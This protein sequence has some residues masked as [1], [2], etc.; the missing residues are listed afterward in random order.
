MLDTEKKTQVS[1]ILRH[2]ADSIDISES[3]YED[4]VEKY[5]AVG[6][7]LGKEGSPL[8]LYNPEISPQGSFNLGTIVK[9]VS[10]EDTYDIDLVCQLDISQNGI[11]QQ[12]LKKMV[13]D[14]LKANKT[15]AG[16]L[17]KEGRRCWT[18]NYADGANFHMDILPA[19]PDDYNWL[20]E[21]DVPYVFARY[22]ICITDK[23][24]WH[25]IP[26]W[27]RSNPKGY[28]GWFR[29]RMI[30]VFESQRKFL[31]EQLR[32]NIEDVPDYKVKTP[33]QR[34][35]QILK[36]H[37]DIMFA[38]DSDGIPISIII[39]TLAAHAYSNETDLYETLISLV[40]DMP[41]YIVYRD[42][43]LWVPNPVNP[44]ENFADKWQE[45]PERAVKFRNW[46]V[47][48]EK[49]I[50]ATLENQGIHEIADA[51]KPT[52]GEKSLNEAM[53]MYGERIKKQRQN[54]KLKMA[55]GSGM[56][57]VNGQTNVRDHTFYGREVERDKKDQSR[58][59]GL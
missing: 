16:M 18:L 20:I 13:G 42:S 2:L 36:R 4:A 53:V 49:D 38:N 34:A 32:A 57:G 55:A 52:F 14:R 15:Y 25:L 29:Q 22:A 12:L 28:A 33:L 10:Q 44:G 58:G 41:R 43:I 39:T 47:K 6:N 46:L 26:G 50:T 3:R 48:V 45:H 51:L 11:T 21:L 9:P 27:P 1:Q 37:R 35:I 23:D 8:V 59:T 40:K 19:I 7:W 56:L 5:E 31:A 30:T 54:G 24:R 17:D